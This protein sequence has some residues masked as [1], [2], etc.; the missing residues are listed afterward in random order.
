MPPVELQALTGPEG[1]RNLRLPELYSYKLELK[2]A[3]C[4]G[5]LC[6]HHQADYEEHKKAN[7][8]LQQQLLI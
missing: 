5:R 1:S 6:I 3:T 4:F 7:T 8:Y 2:A